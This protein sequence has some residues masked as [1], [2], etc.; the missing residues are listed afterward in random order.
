[1]G[2]ERIRATFLATAGTLP[3]LVARIDDFTAP[4][5]GTWDVAGL[6]GHTLR[7]VRTVLTYL[8]QPEPLS[9]DL[10]DAADYFTAAMDRRQADPAAVDAAVAKRGEDELAGLGRT[11]IVGA[12]TAAA[13][14]AAT[15]LHDTRGFRLVATPFGSLRIDDYLRTRLLEISIHGLDLATAGGVAWAPPDDAVADGLA[16]LIEVAQRRGHGP[17]LLLALTG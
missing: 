7:G 4:G 3:G 12:F 17:G 9:Q 16:M 1:M 2:W 14:E 6:A 13:D 10:S 15:A 5:L 8:G 11:G